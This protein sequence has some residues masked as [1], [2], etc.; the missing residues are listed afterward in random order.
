M[1]LFSIRSV[2]TRETSAPT[3]GLGSARP[4]SRTTRPLAVA[5][6]C[7]WL[8]LLAMTTLSPQAGVL[9]DDE[10]A[11][12]DN[13]RLLERCG[14]GPE[15]LRGMHGQA[16]GPLLNAMHAVLDPV[17]GLALPGVRVVHLLLLPVLAAA[18]HRLLRPSRPDAA[19]P[20]TLAFAAIPMLW[21]VSG[22]VCSELPALI[23][24]VA[25]MLLLLGG[26][27]RLGPTPRAAAPGV[28]AAAV[29]AGGLCY[30]A[31]IL[32][33]AT[34]LGPLA[35]LPLLLRGAVGPR[36]DA[37]LLIAFAAAALAVSAPV[38][39][40]W[41]GL[42]PP[43]QAFVG[44]GVEPWH[45]VLS[46]AYGFLIALLVA[47]RWLSLDRGMLAAMATGAA[48]AFIVNLCWTHV[49]YR[50]LAGVAGRLLPEAG[51]RLYDHAMPAPIAALALGMLLAGGRAVGR[52]ADDGRMLFLLAAGFAMLASAVKITH[53][54]ASAYALQSLPFLALPISVVS[55][56]GRWDVVRIVVGMLLGLAAH[57]SWLAALRG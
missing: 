31:A 10:V 3:A 46:L 54:F 56:V 13:T 14:L 4:A 32:G 49:T 43:Q 7:G 17:T 21:H 34:F 16:P 47:P 12:L 53:Q 5:V 1:A 55:T 51:L 9:F 8:M 15:F 19:L 18:L 35:C 57:A 40:V 23:A 20:L 30:G 42:V 24:A 28:A 11:F 45:L 29:V 27:G 38:F 2:T 39:A 48:V 36:R 52:H 26:L 6:T 22:Y 50:P 33:R 41:R 44:R 37:C 25:G